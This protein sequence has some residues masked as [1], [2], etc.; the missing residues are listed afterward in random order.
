MKK[1]RIDKMDR[2]T[3]KLN[4]EEQKEHRSRYIQFEYLP[5]PDYDIKRGNYD[6]ISTDMIYNKLGQLE[7]LEEQLGC[8]LDVV[9]KAFKK[10]IGWTTDCDFGYDNIPYEFEKYQ[11]DKKFMNLKYNEGLMYIAIQETLEDIE[12][13]KNRR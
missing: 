6:R 13:E 11:N 10:Y 2:L 7:D 5:I 8:P 3:Y 4:A 1:V 12:L 9:V